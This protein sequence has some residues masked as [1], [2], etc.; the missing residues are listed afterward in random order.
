MMKDACCTFN[1]TNFIEKRLLLYR[2]FLVCLDTQAL[3]LSSYACIVA[4]HENQSAR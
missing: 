1:Y 2:Y 4:M 3:A